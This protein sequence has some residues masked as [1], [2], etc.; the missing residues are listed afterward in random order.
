MMPNLSAVV[1]GALVALAWSYACLSFAAHLKTQMHVRTGYTRKLFH[2]ESLDVRG[3]QNCVHRF[4]PI[5]K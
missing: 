5:W 3:S 2:D 4:H 1:L